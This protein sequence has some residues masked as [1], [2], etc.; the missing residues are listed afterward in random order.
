MLLISCEIN[1]NTKVQDYEH[2]NSEIYFE[3]TN[4]PILSNSITCRQSWLKYH[5]NDTA[6]Q[7]WNVATES[8]QEIC[9][10]SVTCNRIICISTLSSP[11]PR[12]KWS[13][14]K[15]YGLHRCYKRCL[16]QSP[17]SYVSTLMANRW[18]HIGEL[19]DKTVN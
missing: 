4:L 18:M 15:F 17:R 10:R 8:F 5:H 14:C 11:L 19:N 7:K 2:H 1:W 3:H 6:C 16:I 13:P 9:H 12:S